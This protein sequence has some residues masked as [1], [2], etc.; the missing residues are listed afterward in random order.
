MLLPLLPVGAATAVAAAWSKL[1]EDLERCEAWL[2][3]LDRMLPF[4]TP[5][6]SLPWEEGET[7]ELGTFLLALCRTTRL[8]DGDS[9]DCSFLYS[10]VRLL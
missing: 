9:L 6:L 8:L 2:P 4:T 3:V 10:D 5:P 7:S 1:G